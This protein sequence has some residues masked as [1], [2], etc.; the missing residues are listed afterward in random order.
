VLILRA[1]ARFAD[2]GR[3][4]AAEVIA[5]RVKR[6]EHVWFAGHWGFQ[7]YAERAGA[8]CLTSTPPYPAPNDVIVQSDRSE[9]HI[10]DSVLGEYVL[11]DQVTDTTPGGRVM[12]AEDGAAFYSDSRG[13]LPWAWSTSFIDRFNVWRVV[14]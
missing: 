5:P 9:G 12:S 6:G 3:R 4:V 11:I 10:I 1:D 2:V 13:L 8:R 14:R 7:W